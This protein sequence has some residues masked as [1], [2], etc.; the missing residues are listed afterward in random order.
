[1]AVSFH[2]QTKHYST[3]ADCDHIDALDQSVQKHK[4][5]KILDP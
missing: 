3:S 1:M 2:Y 5:S 4:Q